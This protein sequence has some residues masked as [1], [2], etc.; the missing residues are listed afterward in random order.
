MF[1]IITGLIIAVPVLKTPL[2]TDDIW[3]STLRAHN[4][5]NNISPIEYLIS[6]SVEFHNI[7]RLAQL[8]N[9]IQ[10][11][12]SYFI[13][14]RL[15]Y[16][17]FLIL[18]NIV[19]G[20]YI[21]KIIQKNLLHLSSYYGNVAFFI[22]ISFGQ[23]RNYYD[24][25]T[26]IAGI[27][28]FSSITMII[29]VSYAIRFLTDNRV[30]NLY[31]STLF[32]VVSLYIYEMTYFILAPFFAIFFAH[33]LLTVNG[34]FLKNKSHQFI[35]LIM[36]LI[37]Y[38]IFLWTHF[39]SNSLQDDSTINYS[40]N[41]AQE[42]FRKQFWGSFPAKNFGSQKVYE[43][44]MISNKIKVLILIVS[45]SG[46]IILF[47]FLLVLLE[48]KYKKTLTH[49]TNRRN[50]KL[51]MVLAI[52]M[53]LIPAIVTSLTLRF[54]RDIQEGLP[55]AS[56]YYFQVGFSLL[57][58]TFLCILKDAFLEVTLTLILLLFVIYSTFVTTVV[59]YTV[60]NPNFPLNDN[61]SISQQVLGWDR[62][63]VEDFARLGF[64]ESVNSNKS[65]F[66]YPQF[67]W[68]TKEYL[69]LLSGTQISV[70]DSPKWWHNTSKLPSLDCQ[71]V[72]DCGESLFVQARG[73]DFKNGVLKVSLLRDLQIEKGKVFSHNWV[74]YYTNR[75]EAINSL[76][77]CKQKLSDNG[78]YFSRILNEEK[79]HQIVKFR[80]TAIKRINSEALNNCLN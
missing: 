48:K 50:S 61:A 2:G 56:F 63:T 45:I 52:S 58:V 59:N 72:N 31:L 38:G 43:P 21:R 16:K 76:N 37:Q 70:I 15:L 7:G 13:D 65:Y 34:Q 4:A 39:T 1:I 67:A 11:A 3:M 60:T 55:Y 74:L 40:W 51:I 8:A 35:S 29:C 20:L 17:S 6:K 22:F 10:W 75:T 9:F 24:P 78:V 80:I 36:I 25:R 27:C 73:F 14:Q 23:L 68:T 66:F 28:L 62:E 32:G 5:F 77:K 71:D 19:V 26:S 30:Y 64:F 18:L 46:A 44:D 33:L 47:K 57:I 79:F 42:T 49:T 69:S 53:M 54:Q 12:T 41:L